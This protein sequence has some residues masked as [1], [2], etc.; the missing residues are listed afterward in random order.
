LI[1]SKGPDRVHSP[2]VF[3]LYFYNL[4]QKTN[5][6]AFQEIEKTYSNLSRNQDLIGSNDLGAGTSHHGVTR[7][8]G[9]LVKTSS[10]PSKWGK[11]LFKITN[12]YQPKSILELGTAFGKSAAYLSMGCKKA[13]ITSI[14]GDANIVKYCKQNFKNLKI[15]NINLLQSSVER[16]LDNHQKNKKY[17]LV[18]IDANHTYEATIKYFNSLIPFLNQEAIVIFDDIYWSKQM[19]KA[20]FEIQENERVTVSLDLFRLGIVFLDR[21]QHKEYFKL[22]V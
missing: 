5:Y 16:F 10:I 20:W 7:K 21:E 4:R 12:K 6:Y 19:T 22:R 11:I 13:Q 9:K 14:E 18:F 15:N 17:D 1:T 2:F 8:V 3:D